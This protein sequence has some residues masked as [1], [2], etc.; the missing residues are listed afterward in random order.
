MVAV[1]GESVESAVNAGIA[2][3][4]VTT[5]VPVSEAG[6]VVEQAVQ[7]Q[8]PATSESSYS[9]GSQEHKV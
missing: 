4:V 5:S 7:G 8:H 2:E 3:E 1:Y 6:Q 9:S